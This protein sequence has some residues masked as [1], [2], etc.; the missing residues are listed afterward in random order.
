MTETF[1]ELEQ[2]ATAFFNDGAY[3]HVLDLLTVA[4]TQFPEE[5][6]FNYYLRICAAAR[7]EDVNQACDLLA[8]ALAHDLWF[9]ETVLRES[10]SL[11]PLN[12]HERFEALVADSI[13]KMDSSATEPVV[14]TAVPDT[15]P[16]YPL[17]LALH[18][19]GSSVAAEFGYWQAA[20]SHGWC[21]VAPQ[22]ATMMLSGRYYWTSTETAVAEINNH[23]TRLKELYPIDWHNVVVG[24]FSM[25]ADVALA[26]ALSGALPARRFLLVGPGGPN[27]HEPENMLPLITE[28]NG[29]DIKGLILMSE[30]DPHIEPDK[31]RKIGELLHEGGNSCELVT[32]RGLSH[33]YP[34]DFNERLVAFLQ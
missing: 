22:S 8:A 9:A 11:V 25:G 34:P 28:A 3:Q 1:V 32:Y 27:F 26:I 30:D 24:G 18:G 17:L 7:L 14:K 29:R 16:P 12:G 31:I 6:G 21:V 33:E 23:L 10:P 15:P 2:K 13:A 19:N 5:L 20:V 4:E